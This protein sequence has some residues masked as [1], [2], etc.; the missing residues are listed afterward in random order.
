MGDFNL[1]ILNSNDKLT[2]NFVGMMFDH[3]YNPLIN[4]PT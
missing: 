4:E 3:G 2:E 1:K